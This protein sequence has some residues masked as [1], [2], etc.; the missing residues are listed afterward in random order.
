M[1]HP[2][3]EIIA[4]VIETKLPEG[5]ALIRDP[6]CVGEQR[7]PLF[8]SDEKSRATWICDVDS[9]LVVGR[10]IRVIIEVDESD[11]KPTQIAGKFLA[12]A[13]STHYSHKN[14]GGSIP[15]AESVTF[16]QF[17]ST[18]ALP[19]GTSKTAQWINIE[20]AIRNLLPVGNITHYH[21]FYGLPDE[22]RSGETL[23]IVDRAVE[24]ALGRIVPVPVE[25][26]KPFGQRFAQFKGAVPGLPA[27]LA[28]QH[29][30]YRLGTPKR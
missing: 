2:L 22:F 27:D 25:Q 3:H 12:S 14:A 16:L 9:L 21:L 7:I 11:V 29:E 5:M 24:E 18:S 20:R 6:A 30:F 8:L 17:L 23:R 10:Q 15:K 26:A 1:P 19:N 28:K 13:I 4:D